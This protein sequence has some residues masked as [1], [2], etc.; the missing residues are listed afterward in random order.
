M[1]IYSKI[2]RRYDKYS[3]YL[4][5]ASL[6]LAVCTGFTCI[7]PFTLKYLHVRVWNVVCEQKTNLAVKPFT[8]AAGSPPSSILH[9]G[10][11]FI[12]G[13]C[14]SKLHSQMCH[15]GN[16]SKIDN[17]LGLFTDG[18]VIF[19]IREWRDCYSVYISSENKKKITPQTIS[20]L[21]IQVSGWL[22]KIRGRTY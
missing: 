6:L 18:S 7:I 22:Y 4:T 11:E 16:M 19:W 8:R 20:P 14:G 13:I 3:T 17:T 9:I 5:D 10:Y 12:R 15:G 1:P 2:L 21:F